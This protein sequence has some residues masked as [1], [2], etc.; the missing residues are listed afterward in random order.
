MFGFK[1]YQH[2]IS[3]SEINK[4]I[5]DT[6]YNQMSSGKDLAKNTIIIA[7]GKIATQMVSFFLLPLYT[8]VLTT[9]EYGVVD[10]VITW[11]QLLIPIVSCQL[12]Q[13]IFR[14]LLDNRNDEEKKK[15]ILS[16]IM[17]LSFL[18]MFAFSIVYLF[19]T[20]FIKSKFKYIFLINLLSN[21]YVTLT[22]Q[23]A[24]GLGANI[25]YAAG[26]F[27]S[28]G[29]QVLLNIFLVLVLKLGVYGM[30]IS[31]FLACTISGIYLTIAT[32]S[33]KYIQVVNLDKH[34]LKKYLKYSMPLV[35]NSMSW[36]MLNASDRIIILKFL[37][38]S[39]NGIYSAANKFSGIYTTIYNIF[40][41]SWTEQ[42]ALH[43]HDKNADVEIAKL[44][45]TVIRFFSCAFLCLTAVIPFV[46]KFLVNEKFNAAYY[47]IP[48]LLA[49]AFFSAMAGVLGAYYVAEKM[50]GIIAKMTTL[51][52][53]LNVIINLLFIKF[54][55]LYAASISTFTAYLVVFIVR[56]IDV[57]KYFKIRIETSVA[58]GTMVL[59]LLIWFAY[60]SKNLLLC[61]LVLVITILYSFIL[62]RAL[63]FSTIYVIKK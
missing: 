20:P 27:I 44:Q 52:A 49:G 19:L 21:V 57:R 1:Y 7:M 36:W 26:S 33:Y 31:M 30:L 3:F 62:N 35:P 13:S 34:R 9:E 4:N 2:D 6:D 8:A 22:L 58:L 53:V 23:I 16:D 14:F 56:Y 46:F 32:K 11:V 12:D 18:L 25:V 28:A 61:T 43:M 24:R 5:K 37:N 48:I 55:G 39:V 50:T 59:M 17:T 41:L 15:E 10:L 47:Q 38:I 63:L 45:S 51:A 40:N 42:I 54:I 60:Y 29:G